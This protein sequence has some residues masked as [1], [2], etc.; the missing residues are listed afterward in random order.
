L[1]RCEEAHWNRVRARVLVEAPDPIGVAGAKDVF[2]QE[3]APLLM[4]APQR[5]SDVTSQDVVLFRAQCG[6]PLE[7]TPFWHKYRADMRTW[8][9]E[10]YKRE[11]IQTM[12]RYGGSGGSG[13]ATELSSSND[14]SMILDDDDNLDTEH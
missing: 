8:Q 1:E 9:Q 7:A 2:K 12:A 3:V 4:R 10:H 14:D 6:P 13:G 11:S 5:P